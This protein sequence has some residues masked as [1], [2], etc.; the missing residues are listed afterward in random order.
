MAQCQVSSSRSGPR[1]IVK[2]IR[3][4]HDRGSGV[5]DQPHLQRCSRHRRRI[6]GRG[7]E[8]EGGLQGQ[9]SQ[10]G[11]E[12]Q[13]RGSVLASKEPLAE[14]VLHALD[15]VR[16]HCRGKPDDVERELR[17]R[18]HD[19]AARHR[20]ERAYDRQGGRLP[21]HKVGDDDCEEGSGG[22]DRL[23]EGG[24]DVLQAHEPQDDGG[25]AHGTHQAHLPQA[26]L[27]AAGLVALAGGWVLKVLAV[28]ARLACSQDLKQP[29]R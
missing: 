9:G 11:V 14:H 22:L 2:D 28:S 17:V 19:Q 6:R 20:Y 15:D 25:E 23:C 16:G 26:A 18:D 21:Q 29:L 24:R 5:V 10:R 3:R 13:L 4:F 7:Q 8:H 27:P 12:L 1:G